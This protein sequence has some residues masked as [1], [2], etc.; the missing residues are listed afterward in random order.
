MYLSLLFIVPLIT[1]IAVWFCKGLKQVRTVALL[2]SV[3][4]LLLAFFLLYSFYQE[5]AAG[6]ITQMLFD[7]SYTWFAPLNINY[8]VGVDGISLAMIVLTSFMVISGVLVSWSIDTLDRE[9]FF[10][11]LFLSMGASVFF[12]SLAL[13]VLFFF[14]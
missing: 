3:V 1:V 12:I 7:Y 2:S 8:H 6:N 11:L 14:L 13:F 4:Q 9:F 5:R 10:L